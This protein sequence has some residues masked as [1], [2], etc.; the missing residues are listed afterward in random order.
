MPYTYEFQRPGFTVDLII[1]CAPQ[2]SI[3]LIQRGNEPFKG[4]WAMPGGYVEEGE[5]ILAAAMR[6]LREETGIT[7]VKLKQMGTYGDPG[8]DPRGWT[9]TV[10]FTGQVAEPVAT[11]G[12]DARNAQWFP[13]D[14]LP[15]QMAF[16]HGIIVQDI[17]NKI[18]SEY[19]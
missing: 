7:D 3:L 6:E 17:I 14:Q 12:D 10:V 13:M 16:D 8:R 4:Q 1:V 15:S 19:Q 2:R 18:G 11:A 9:A 5:T